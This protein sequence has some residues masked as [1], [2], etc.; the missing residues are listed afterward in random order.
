MAADL[1]AW[2]QEVDGDVIGYTFSNGLSV[3][4]EVGEKD[5]RLRI[6]PLTRLQRAVLN[7]LMN[8]PSRARGKR[9]FEPFAGSGA[10]G[11]MALRLG[12]EH[13]DL[14]DV[15]P[16]AE[17][18]HRRTASANGFPEHRV[19]STVAD[20][21]E[22]QPDEP[23]DLVLAN[24]PFVPTPDCI[25]GTLNSNGGPEGNELLA[26]LVER[27]DDFVKPDGEALVIL[28][29]LVQDGLPL[30]A[31]VFGPQLAGRRTEFTPLQE[32]PVPLERFCA[33]C[34]IQHP[35]EAAGIRQWRSDLERQY[36]NGLTLSHYVMHIGPRSDAPGVCEVTANASQKFG[37]ECVLPEENADFL[38]VDGRRR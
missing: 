18:F 9:V 4:A 25:E 16:R 17:Q 3:Q 28:Y 31:R 13:V 34:E 22:F 26:A 21:R 24:P 6:L 37:A 14:L 20:I 5:D 7:Y 29:Q 2:T 19:R 15:N 27:L 1:A 30:A 35:A 36:G 38:P 8:D 33:A 32:V 12:A 23:Y 10:F 11:F